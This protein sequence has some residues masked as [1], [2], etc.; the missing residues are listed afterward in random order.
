MYTVGVR[1]DTGCGYTQ[2][3]DTARTDTWYTCASCTQHM[4]AHNNKV[5]MAYHTC[6]Y[7]GGAEG[8]WGWVSLQAFRGQAVGMSMSGGLLSHVAMAFWG[9][10]PMPDPELPP[11]LLL[12]QSGGCPRVPESPCP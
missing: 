6:I 7:H 5:L 9:T 1:H 3:V 4:G 12:P 2:N 8:P 10:P 11:C